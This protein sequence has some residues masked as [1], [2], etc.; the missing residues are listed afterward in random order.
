MK[1]R[2]LAI[3]LVSVMLL[4]TIPAF[5][6]GAASNPKVEALMD[7]KYYRTVITADTIDVDG[8]MDDVYKGS[9]RIYANGASSTVD[10]DAYTVVNANGMYVFAEVKGDAF[11]VYALMDDG[12]NSSWGY[13]EIAK[14]GTVSAT[15]KEGTTLLDATAAVVT[16]TD[17]WRAEIY[18]PF[19]TN[20]INFTNYNLRVAFSAI[21]GSTA[22]YDRSEVK[23]AESS[24]A[25]YKP[26][27]LV[28][29]VDRDPS[30]A[31][32]YVYGLEEIFADD[33]VPVYGGLVNSAVY[34]KSAPTLDGKK[35]AAIYSEH[36]RI[37]LVTWHTYH[38][39]AAEP[40]GPQ[41]SDMG[42]VYTAF[43][44]NNLYVYY[45]R[46]DEELFGS[47]QLQMFYYFKDES[48]NI[49]AGYMNFEIDYAWFGNSNTNWPGSNISSEAMPQS[50][51]VRAT[52]GGNL[53]GAEYKMPLPDG[54]K[55]MLAANKDVSIKLAF[56]TEQQTTLN[57]TKTLVNLAGSYPDTYNMYNY[58]DGADFIDPNNH[59]TTMILSKSFTEDKYG[60]I[61]GASLTLGSDINVNYYA[62]IGTGDV[63]N[64]Y[65]KF[66]RR[67]S[68]SDSD[69][70]EYIAYPR[71]VEGSTMYMFTFAGF[72]PHNIGDIIDAELYIDG[73]QVAKK[74]GYSVRDNCV[75]L[76]TNTTYASNVKLDNLVRA[77]LNYGA[78][79]QKYVGGYDFDNL[80]NQGCRIVLSTPADT[81]SVRN[82]GTPISDSLKMTSAGVYF[83]N[84]NKIYVKF[85]APSLD[86]VTVTFNGVEA[87]V[88]KYGVDKNGNQVYIAYSD[89]IP[90]T[91]FG[92]PYTIVLSNGTASQTAVYSVNSYAYAK[93]NSAEAETKELA[94]ATFTYGEAAKKY[95]GV[96]TTAYTVM[97]YNDA[98][99]NDPYENLHD[100]VM[101]IIKESMPDLIGM[102]EVQ[103]SQQS[104][105]ATAFGNINYGWLWESRG[106]SSGDHYY[107]ELAKPSGVA[108]AYNKDKFEL[109]S[110]KHLW[111]SDT[112][113]T[114]SKYDDSD[115]TYDFHAALLR[116]KTTG[117]EF[118]F[119]SAHCDYTSTANVKQIAKL[120]E[121]CETDNQYL[122]YGSYRKIYVADWNFSHL[123]SHTGLNSDGAKKMNAAGYKDTGDQTS[124]IYKPSTTVNGATID[125][126][127][128][129]PT[130]FKAIDYK[131]INTEL[132][133]YTS[134]HYPVLSKVVVAEA[135][136]DVRLEAIYDYPELPEDPT[137]EDFD[138]FFYTEDDTEDFI[139]K[140]D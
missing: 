13:Y 39:D 108:I 69:V 116:D 127:F 128:T 63:N 42:Y 38:S 93:R 7:A 132:A 19:T 67:S 3:V 113:D 121:L 10:F 89:G 115:Y 101:T 54:I 125:C 135:Y 47:E 79:A 104:A 62:T 133:L 80:A 70:K 99:N 44:D 34:V 83:D 37:P 5:S 90:A 134:D 53:Y 16:T 22:C 140:R 51:Y 102:Q 87:S 28:T 73:E 105:Y 98:D 23:N 78:A 82:T 50:N 21:S 20:I 9:Q 110:H 131:V 71:K 56:G 124:G 61:Y 52:L 11:R 91:Q 60:E 117:E 46:Y 24:N 15:T 88:E 59:G 31:P 77:L 138:D 92:L 86:G 81:D 12:R 100:D 106:A 17:G 130:E 2:I 74:E 1:K 18:I 33:D 126:C 32:N 57:G 29:W 111:L 95:V 25:N 8:K 118:V 94:L 123:G 41:I 137:Y 120:L 76:L 45:E 109:V 84:E 64:T 26:I 114:A 58:A 139:I 43:D 112:P 14:G 4:A 55:A 36:N 75:N 97:T 119:V 65:M 129:K 49:T 35:D 66:T 72:G 30:Y 48:G 85:V 68:K 96:G 122:S 136:E 27:R 6:V 40:I 107:G 103:K